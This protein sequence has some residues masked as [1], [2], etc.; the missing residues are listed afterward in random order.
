MNQKNTPCQPW[1]ETPTCSED[2]SLEFV[3][4]LFFPENLKQDAKETLSMGI[5]MEVDPLRSF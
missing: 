1:R 5:T 3:D 2:N 4:S